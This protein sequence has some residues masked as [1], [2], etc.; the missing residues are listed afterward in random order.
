[1]ARSS[2]FKSA[3]L[4]TLL[5]GSWFTA[6]QAEDFPKPLE[7]EPIPAVEVLPEQYPDSWMFVHDFNF[8]SMIDSRLAV[9]DLLGEKEQLKGNVPSSHFAHFL[10]AKSSKEIYVAETYYSRMVRGKRNDVIT[11]YDRDTLAF[12]DEIELPDG[13][14]GQMIQLPNNFQFTNGEAWALVFNFT[15]ASS[16]RI[17]DL[18]NRVILNEIDVPGCMLTFPTAERGFSTMCSDGTLSTILL[19]EK[20]QVTQEQSSKSFNDIDNDP[21]FMF[22]TQGSKLTHFLSYGGDVQTIDFSGETP[23][24]KERWALQSKG[25][26]TWRPGGWQITTSDRAGHLYALMH[27]DGKEGS[28]KSGGTEVW[29]FD[30]DKKERVKRI[31]LNSLAWSI[32]VSSGDKPLLV[33]AGLDGVMHVY[34][35]QTGKH[36]QHLHA[37]VTH[38]PVAM[39]PAR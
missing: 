35:A 10:M 13:K 18:K 14:R 24:I 15:P 26:E 8:N 30:V 38:N 31:K 28:H 12:K 32:G 4:A 9:V 16:V 39:F 20:G 34:D 25:E 36:V 2:A 5:T 3:C 29:V 17:V 19:D 1:M 11:I 21:L 7:A 22:P 33:A 23:V 27:A 37:T 6:V